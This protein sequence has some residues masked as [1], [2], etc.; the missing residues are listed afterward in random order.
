MRNIDFDGVRY[1]DFDGVILDTSDL[2]FHEWRK[3]PLHHTLSEEEKIEYIK[4]CDWEYIVYNAPVIN[5]SLYILKNMNPKNS[6]ILTTFH[7]LNE[8]AF[9]FKRLREE[10]VKQ[11]IILVPYTLEKFE[12]VVPRGS[13]LVDDKL[14]NLTGWKKSGGI[15]LFFDKNG[16]NYDDWGIYNDK[17]YQ[18][19]RR[20]DEK[21]RRK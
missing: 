15:P 1:I 10:G 13:I 7:S 18:R 19:V 5:D 21:V 14:G 17:G 16:N 8:G 20:I 6:F 2:L 12:A 9:K 3:N 4:N 11:N